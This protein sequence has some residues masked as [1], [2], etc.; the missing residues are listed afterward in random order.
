M[1]TQKPA[2]TAPQKQVNETPRHDQILSKTHL[3]NSKDK[4]VDFVTFPTFHSLNQSKNRITGHWAHHARP[5]RTQ[6]P[7]YL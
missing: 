2:L 6:K 1:L 4:A 5:K 7:Q 3:N